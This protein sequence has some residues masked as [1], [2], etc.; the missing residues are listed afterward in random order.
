MTRSRSANPSASA[1]NS[2]NAPVYIFYEI[3]LYSFVHMVTANY[4]P[5]HGVMHHLEKNWRGELP[6]RKTTKKSRNFQARV[7]TTHGKGCKSVKKSRWL[8]KNF[9]KGLLVLLIY[10]I[11]R[12]CFFPYCFNTFCTSDDISATT[13]WFY[14]L[15]SK[16]EHMEEWDETESVGGYDHCTRNIK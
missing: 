1:T 13:G 12:A 7:D 5:L 10:G 9:T 3:L 6:W 14:C 2:Q 4:A 11:L 16:D 15:R 8:D